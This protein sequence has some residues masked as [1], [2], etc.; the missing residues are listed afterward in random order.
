[1]SII[2]SPLSVI[3]PG[4]GAGD[5]VAEA[6]NEEAR[7]VLETGKLYI[8]T[9]ITCLHAD[10]LYHVEVEGSRH[11]VH[12]C[13]WGAGIFCALLGFKTTLLP[14]V[15]TRVVV[16]AGRN[17]VIVQSI[18]SDPRD[19]HAGDTRVIVSP[20]GQIELGNLKEGETG[21]GVFH[22]PP[23]E[24]L[25]GEFEISNALGVAIQFLTNLIKLQ[26]S[27]RAKVEVH[28][29]ND[30]VRVISDTFKHFNAFGDHQIYN[31]GGL[32]VRWDGTSR[33]HEALGLE[34][35]SE[36][37]AQVDNNEVDFGDDLTRAGRWRYSQFIGFLGDFVHEFIT[38]P[39][40]VL[41]DIGE[42]TRAG[43]SR[44]WRGNDGSVLLQ[45]VTEIAIERVVRIPV[46]MEKKRWD[47]P[48]GVLK[49][50]WQQ[51]VSGA[52]QFT[53]VWNY[54]NDNKKIHE[55]T[56]LL[57][58]YARWLSCFHS[59]ARF[60]QY[61]AFGEEW[62]IPKEGD[63]EHSWTN[64]EKDVKQAN[65]NLADYY[66]TYAC[67]RI[68]R[69]GAIVLYDGYGSSITMTRSL[70]Q[71]SATRHLELEAAGDIRIVAGNDIY[72]RARRHVEL[73]A[74]VGNFFAKARTSWK[75][76]CEW[77]TMWLKSDAVD[78]KKEAPPE[79]EGDNDPEVELHDA[80]LLLDTSQGRMTLNSVRTLTLQTQGKK[81]DSTTD[82]EDISASVILQ[83]QSQDIR[84]IGQRNVFAVSKGAYKGSLAL[85]AMP[86]ILMKSYYLLS[87]A[88]FVDF[89]KQITFRYNTIHAKGGIQTRWVYANLHI[90][91]P[92][93][94]PY[95]VFMM[96]KKHP[97]PY[98]PH[99]Q[100][101]D[102]IRREN[103]NPKLASEDEV[104]R[105]TSYK[106]L[107]IK[108]KSAFDEEDPETGPE[109]TIYSDPDFSYEWNNPFQDG[110]N[111]EPRF[112]PWAQ[113]HIRVDEDGSDRYDEWQLMDDRLKSA[114]RTS[115]GETPYPG[116]AMEMHAPGEKELLHKI[117]E[118]KY[119]EQV[120]NTGVLS[121]KS[122]S[123][124]FLKL[125]KP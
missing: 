109:L 47:D 51:M 124:Y 50:Y 119:S 86:T 73:V 122:F 76:L 3:N 43:K 91:G 92:K 111:E 45:S 24:L 15:G 106:D 62:V 115:A 95:A 39:G 97:A 52:K 11:I 96:I 25:D 23:H 78:P 14:T 66:D 6:T 38:D 32:N 7:G 61:E 59:Y 22:T 101:V 88:M 87:S 30:M 68:M 113:Q 120:P 26:G 110:S 33:E 5:L 53:Q 54:G 13:I 94:P 79:P 93:T 102:Y 89:N 49:K 123:R 70:I 19:P 42:S 37:R 107:E 48:E 10:Q 118:G 12:N 84:L 57:R 4:A 40:A 85:E 18:P 34:E 98:R 2:S 77:G 103:Q 105:L 58:N 1:M 9:I 41:A 117:L 55:A 65:P 80:A 20:T 125:D 71:I 63:V 83:S 21:L 31:D 64:Q 46:P 17:P 100:H 75:A 44:F 74:T 72:I 99:G 121:P 27:E 67:F 104:K 16:L 90:A 112:E 8:G 108:Y 82:H 114:P 81:P 29:L 116:R 35:E 60:H 69:D 36:E 28:L 56:Y